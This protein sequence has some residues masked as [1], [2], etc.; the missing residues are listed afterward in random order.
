MPF[1]S[2]RVYDSTE[3]DK[4][5]TMED[6]FKEILVERLGVVEVDRSDLANY[7]GDMYAIARSTKEEDENDGIDFFF[8]TNGRWVGIDFTTSNV[9]HRIGKD[10][11]VNQ[12]PVYVIK[13]QQNDLSLA[14]QGGENFIHKVAD[15]LNEVIDSAQKL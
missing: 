2:R 9:P 3:S 11:S 4:G 6:L 10:R 15:A 1:T 5:H 13:L 14:S 12:I 7:H 8:Y